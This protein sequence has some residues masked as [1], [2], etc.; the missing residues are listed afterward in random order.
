LNRYKM[1]SHSDWEFTVRLEAAAAEVVKTITL[2]GIQPN[3]ADL[4]AAHALLVEIEKWK[5]MCLK[6]R[7]G[8]AQQ[9]SPRSVWDA[10]LG[11]LAASRDRDALLSIMELKGFGSSRDEDSGQRRAKV[12]TAAMRFLKPETWGVVDW[13]NATMLGCLK[14]S[15]GDV[16]AAITQAKKENPDK[17]RDVFDVIDEDGACEYNQAYRQMKT[18]FGF[19]R[20]ADAEMAVFGL[21]LVAWP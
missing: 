12:A 2:K 19:T 11:A 18:A 16:D 13:R 1:W 10:F 14:K 9:N 3:S 8:N 15:G 5:A 20:T 7:M 6:Q 17:L 21:S 4:S